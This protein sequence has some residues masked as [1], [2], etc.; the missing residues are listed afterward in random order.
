MHRSGTSCLAGTL[1]AS[2]V[3]LGDVVERGRFNAKGSRELK[4]VHQLNEGVLADN[5]GSWQNPPEV[6]SWSAERLKARLQILESFRDQMLWGLKDPRITLML[7]SWKV[8]LE[9]ANVDVIGSYRHP[10]AVANSLATRNGIPVPRGLRIWHNYNR[11]LLDAVRR[12]PFPLIDFDVDAGTYGAQI[13]HALQVLGL[14]GTERSA[15]AFFEAGL[16]HE[17]QDGGE[18]PAEISD[19]FDSL[20]RISVK[21]Q[22]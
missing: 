20:T 13:A 14:P 16:V 21:S 11:R 15:S 3:Y 8:A 18:L 6:V 19:L 12:E 10:L 7:D 1:Q 2:G 4:I 5:G 9:P 17:S 22:L